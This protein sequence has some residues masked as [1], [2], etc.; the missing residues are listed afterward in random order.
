MILK[1]TLLD[2]V[3]IIRYEKRYLEDIKLRAAAE[4]KVDDNK[5]EKTAVAGGT[6]EVETSGKTVKSKSSKSSSTEQDLDTFL[7]GDLE[8]SDGGL[9]ILS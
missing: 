6:E 2:F 5:V 9:D 7:L 3:I 4:Q 8:D 1:V